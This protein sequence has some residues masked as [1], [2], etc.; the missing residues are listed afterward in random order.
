MTIHVDD[1][2]VDHNWT[3]YDVLDVNQADGS[4]YLTYSYA[5]S[6]GRWYTSSEV[7]SWDV[8]S[9]GVLDKWTDE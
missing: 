7:A 6:V 8:R 3:H 4:V 5:D 9:E 1:M 2:L